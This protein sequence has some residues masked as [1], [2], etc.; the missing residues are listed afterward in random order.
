MAITEKRLYEAFGLEAPAEEPAAP[1]A[2]PSA[3]EANTGAQEQGVAAPAEAEAAPVTEPNTE[4]PADDAAPEEPAD[5]ADSGTDAGKPTMTP[6]QRR[7]NAARRR[8]Q[9]QQTA[10][11]NA[12]AAALKAER[13]R[14]DAAMQDFF[15]KA[16]LKDTF[17][18]QPIK[19]LEEFQSW[20][21]K[22]RASQLEAQLKSGKLTPEALEQ[23]ITAHP[24]MQQ[25]QKIVQQQE[26]S[27]KAQQEAAD[28]ARIDAEIAQ[29]SKED[30]SIQSVADLLKMPT[31][32]QFREYVNKGYSFRDAYY[33]ANRERIAQQQAE[34]AKQQA[35]R[36]ASSKDHLKGSGNVRGSGA[37]SVPP[38]QMAMFRRMNPGASDAE[39]QRF[40]N[41]YKIKQGG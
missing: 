27:A 23:A 19:T 31:A 17:T 18:G 9:E 41:D 30:P 33:L 12:V 38:A 16:N 2:E 20:D 13:E 1:V 26:A 14:Q 5:E 39:I 22:Y 40:Y 37:D 8:Q 7:E 34:A 35:M 15:A 21:Q 32:A 36:N 4:P 10:I 25:A 24:L 29:I 3:A 28:K 6:E 11:D